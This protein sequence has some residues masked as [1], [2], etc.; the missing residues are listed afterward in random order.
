[1]SQ[2]KVAIILRTKDRPLYLRRAIR[3]I[4]NQTYTGYHVYVV[5]DGG[6]YDKIQQVFSSLSEGEKERF[7]FIN[8]PVSTKR[9]GAL[10]IGVNSASED[11]IH[12]HDDDDT[13]EPEFL[14][15]TVS[16]LDDDKE[17]IFSGV[18]TSNYDVGEQIIGDEIIEVSRRDDHGK[19]KGT[20]LKYSL[21]LAGLVAIAPISFLF[22]REAIKY[23]GSVNPNMDYIEDSEFFIRIMQYADIGIIQDILCSYHWKASSE[24]KE[25]FIT[26]SLEECIHGVLVYKNKI[27]RDALSGKGTAKFLQAQ[28]LKD[29]TING[30]YNDIISRHLTELNKSFME[31]VTI[32]NEFIIRLSQK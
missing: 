13:L 11:Y 14:E 12:I 19:R 5:N 27:V 2:K 4:L 31:L 29:K 18:V 32:L 3:S 6:S 10:A 22:R 30:H 25:H 15:R 28:A 7:S 8:L 17:K 20:V 9:G 16:Y 24:N 26:P 1:M 23:V 21:Y